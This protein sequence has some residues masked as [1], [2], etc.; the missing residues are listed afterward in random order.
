MRRK[1]GNIALYALAILFLGYHL[2]P[3][4]AGIS[5]K[6][7]DQTSAK[8][9]IKSLT[10]SA[11][12]VASDSAYDRLTYGNPLTDPLYTTLPYKDPAQLPVSG[13]NLVKNTGF[14]TIDPETK[15][16]TSWDTSQ[17][18]NNNGKFSLTAGPLG[19]TAARVEV[20]QYKDGDAKWVTEAMPVKPGEFYR[21]ETQYRTSA[22]TYALVD[23]SYADG[24]HNYV[25]LQPVHPS[26]SSWQ[27]YRTSFVVPANVVTMSVSQVIDQAGILDSTGY[28]LVKEPLPKFNRGLVSL[29]FDDGWRSIYENGLPLFE[30]Y[31]IKT[32]Q[33]IISG[34]LDQ[35]AYMTPK[36]I[37]EFEAKGHE[38]GSHTMQHEDLATTND[39]NAKK[40]L[41]GSRATLSHF[42]DW[43]VRN[44]APPYGHYND[45]VKN[46]V[47]QCYESMR[48]TETGFNTAEYDRYDLKVMNIELTTKPEEVATA[49]R[50][51][52]DH[53]LWLVLVYHEVDSK[54]ESAYAAN[55]ADLEKHIKTIKDE[56]VQVVTMAE[57]LAETLPQ[58]K[59]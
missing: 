33:Y 22:Y 56:Q 12:C 41:A 51:A 29:N 46:Y 24:S 28:K 14:K 18:G 37:D 8:T 20:T 45:S 40:T 26:G 44:F 55:L 39:E 34:V 49:V 52:R 57:G 16:P 5:S 6:V 4:G 58:L 9:T 43:R 7:A 17:V 38:I 30:K 13:T 35:P 23:F 59:R 36:M 3:I 42:Y 15:L 53:K 21:F 10:D 2:F 27:T 19:T 47:Q 48:G 50:F 32:T 25:I 31:D 1:L 11:Q 54:S